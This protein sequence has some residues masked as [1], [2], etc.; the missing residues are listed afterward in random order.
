MVSDI[1]IRA[2][3]IVDGS[4]NPWFKGDVAI[5]DGN[6][7]EVGQLNYS[8]SDRVLDAKGLVV[9]PGFI[10][11]HSHSE[12]A[13][14]VDPKAESKVRQGVTT[15]VLPPDGS[16]PA[17]VR[18]LAAGLVY[19]AE[20]KRYGIP[21]WPTLDGYLSE[22]E[23]KGT[24]VNVAPLACFGNIRTCVMGYENRAPTKDELDEMKAIAGESMK[25]GA[26]GMSSGLRYVPQSYSTTDEIIEI[27]KVVAQYD[28][29]YTTHIR[30]EGDEGHYIEAVEE[31]IEIGRRAGVRVN[32]THFH[33]FGKLAWGKSREAIELINAAIENGQEITADNHTYLATSSYLRTWV[34]KWS[35]EG[36]DLR[37]VERLKDPETREKIRQ[38]FTE[39]VDIRGGPENVLVASVKDHP[40]YEGR[41][42]SE[43]AQLR[44]D[45]DPIMAALDLI[46]MSEG[47]AMYINFNMIEEDIRNVLLQPWTMI[48]TDGRALA[49]SGPLSTGNPHPRNYG[50]YPMIFRRYVRGETRPDL[51]REAGAKL[52]PLEEAVRKM[53][54]LP[55]RTLRLQDRGLIRPGMRADI[56]IFDPLTITDRSTYIKPHQYSE[57]VKYLLVNGEIVLDNGEHT[58]M[59]PGWV[60]RK[61]S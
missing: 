29:F 42:L 19:G 22:L 44:R 54:S 34:P 58:S 56:T 10:D 2:G 31:M 14:L 24:A 12:Y 16:G 37:L 23:K 4:G 51:P 11:M 18:G 36:G 28:G 1:L 27:C 6:I 60:L 45:K 38:E 25:D 48:S 46:I 3:R 59:L 26:R 21:G 61:S 33:P 32:Y 40:E 35:H 57:G 55:A 7:A 52:L 53:T 17:P 41:F 13:L 9:S 50:T 30:D 15:E 5:R 49:T 20:A 39:V 47:K 43:I 8:Q